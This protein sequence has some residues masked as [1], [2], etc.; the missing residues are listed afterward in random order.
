MLALGH[1]NLE[2]LAV[3]AAGEKKAEFKAGELKR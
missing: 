2:L 3:C 1:C